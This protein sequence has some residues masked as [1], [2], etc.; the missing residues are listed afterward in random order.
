VIERKNAMYDHLQIRC[1]KLG[2][3]IT[4]AYC[5]KEGGTLPCQRTIL[6]WQHRLPVEAFLKSILNEDQWQRWHNQSP[7]EKMTILLDLIEGARQ[8]I[9]AGE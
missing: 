4:F 1:P 2:G 3:E 8:R 9:Q 6:C 5:R 7:K